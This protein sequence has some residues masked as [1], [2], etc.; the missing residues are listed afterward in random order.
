MIMVNCVSYLPFIC[1]AVVKIIIVKVESGMQSNDRKGRH[2]S[3]FTGSTDCRYVPQT[4]IFCTFLI[5]YCTVQEAVAL[6]WA[7]VSHC[8]YDTQQCSYQYS[9][10]YGTWFCLSWRGKNCVPHVPDTGLYCT[11]Q[12]VLA[13]FGCSQ[14]LLKV[15]SCLV[16]SGAV[17]SGTVQCIIY[18][19]GG[20]VLYGTSTRCSL[21][22]RTGSPV[23]YQVQVPGTQGKPGF[24][25]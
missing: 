19:V 6:E 21:L 20:P 15:Q 8:G 24:L 7:Q 4:C 22:L 10:S 1:C 2:V 3:S 5:V 25:T 17:P 9:T 12:E 23:W 16:R 13:R 11:V 18:S 14:L